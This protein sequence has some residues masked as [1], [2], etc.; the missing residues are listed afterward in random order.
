MAVELIGSIAGAGS[1]VLDVVKCLAA[2]IGRP[3]KY[4]YNYK[5]NIDNLQDGVKNLKNTSEEVQVNVVAAERN[6]EEIKQSVKDWQSKA[7]N[8]ITE[9][10]KLIEEKENNPRCFK[11]L[12]PNWII[13]YKR[14]KKA[15]KLKQDDISQLL[16]KNIHRFLPQEDKVSYP[17][18]HKEIWLRS[19]ED[20]LAFESR[21]STVKDVWGALNDENIYMMGV[22]GMGGLGKTTLVQE[23]GRQAEKDKL[24]EEIVFVEV[25][26]TLDVKKVQTEI[27]DKLGLKFNNESERASKLYERLK[28]GKKILLILDNVWEDLDLKTMGIPSK[29]DHGGCKLLLTTRN[30]DVLQKMDSQKNFG[31]SILQ[32]EE[33]WNL[34]MKMAG[35]VIQTR[36]LNSLP[37]DVCKECGGLPIVICTIAKALK[38]KSSP[39]D[40]KVALRELKAPS[41][42]K[43]IGLLEKE[44][45]KIALS[46]TYLRDDEL[47]KTFLISSLMKNNTSISDLFRHVVGLDILEGANLTMEDARDRLDKLVRELKDSCLLLD[48]FESGQFAMHDAIRA[49]AVT[50]AYTDHHVF[51]RRN[52]IEREWK[53]KDK[54][55]KCTKI[56]LPGNSTI[57]SQLWPKDLDCPNLEYFYMTNT[58]ASSY[59]IPEDFFTV[60]P[61]LK[62]LNLFGMQQSS[63]PSSLDLLTNLQ[64]LC[65]DHSKIEDVAIIRNLKQLK[66]LSLQYSNIKELPSEFGQLTQI[67]LLDLSDCRQ[68]KVI[69]PNLIPKLSQLEEL[70]IKGCC[71]QWKVEVLKELKHLTQLTTLT[72]DVTNDIV[73]P[74]GFFYRELKRYNISIRNERWNFYDWPNYEFSRILEFNYDSTI[75]LEELRILKNVELLRLVEFSDDDNNLKPIFNEKVIFS[76]LMALELKVTSSRKIWD[77]QPPTFMSSLTHLNLKRCRKIKYVFSFSIAKSL[78]TLQHLEIR[79]CEV[80]E[81]I[82]A[83]AEGANNFAFPQVTFLTLENLPKLTTFYHGIDTW[84]LPM[85][86]RL[87]VEECE[88]F[89]SKYLGFHENSLHNSEPK[90]IWLDNKINSDL[91]K[92]ELNNKLRWISW[93]SKSKTLE[94][95]CDKSTNIPL[96]LLQIF[97]NLKELQLESCGYKE[98][99]S[100]GKDEKQMQITLGPS[101]TSFQNL[102]VLKVS[103]CRELMKLITP[104]TA[105]NLVQ[106]REMSIE[107]CGMLIEI[108]ENEGERDATTSIRIVFD[109]LKKLSLRSLESLTCFC[110]GNYSFN[111]PSLEEIIIRECPNMKTFSQGILSTPKLHKINYESLAKDSWTWEKME[112]KNEGN[113]LNK[114]IQGACRKQDISVD[115]KYKAFQDI[116][117]T[118]ICYN[119]HP[120]SFYQN[121][122]HLILSSCGNINYAFPSSI[123]RSLHQLQHLKIHNCKVLEEIVAKEEGANKDDNFVFP[124]VTSLVLENLPEF[125]AFY[126]TFEWPMLQELVLKDCAKFMTS[127]YLSFQE[128][129]EEC[130]PHFSEPKSLFLNDKINSNLEK[131]ELKNTNREIKWQSQ[132][133]ALKIS[134]DKSANF[135][136]GLLQRFENTK[137]LRLDICDEYK[138]IKC[139]SDLPNL[140]VLHV[141]WCNRLT[142]LMPS[143]ASFQNLKVLNVSCC[144]W[145]MKLI[146]PSTTRSLVQLRELS[147]GYCG[148]MI[149][150]V[151]NE[152]DETTTEIVFENLKKLSLIRL[153]SLTCFCSGNYSF[154]FPSFEELIIEECPNMKTFSQ[155]ISSTPKLSKIT[156]EWEEKDLEN[157]GIELNTTI[158]QEHK[159]KMK[160]FFGGGLSMPKLQE[161]NERDCS[162]SDINM[163]IQ[164]LQ[165]D[166]SKIYERF[167][168]EEDSEF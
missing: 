123:A 108:I 129:N 40:W 60:M 143:S 90:F 55:K 47:K 82:V 64:T 132:S 96:G 156:Y 86:K 98:I 118:E 76:N 28:S 44:Y 161:L 75:S 147:I 145:L 19:N 151:E 168:E 57:I 43:F 154:N 103:W 21:N 131:M 56:S 78:Q 15:F 167:P 51:T 165:N 130:E 74:Q 49:V 148:M 119:Q 29:M 109:N 106:L 149:E 65:L 146:I 107:S 95:K 52:D 115:L 155:G 46:Y 37:Q 8:T 136:L 53:N 139:L 100:C 83:E 36:G 84:E 22:Y 50:I 140:E 48:S 54:L 150:I 2:P 58:W 6:V 24:F 160:T 69:A 23:V 33:A 104:S 94:I 14:S 138:E 127:K 62:V 13:R 116:N 39:S 85:L 41:P 133:K 73:L 17:T 71:I 63:L 157:G 117:S 26:E 16:D 152:G 112:V 164:Q 105:R 61:K 35:G 66:V 166:C 162:E 97:E 77:S 89:T 18:I 121:L 111:F 67:R 3:F 59:E 72:L 91:E 158:Q 153:E 159:K 144:E 120:N 81:E 79:D 137:E 25:T 126:H 20:Y 38:N 42:T 45:V 141:I 128:N 88:K 134:N 142:S 101:S 80:L 10:E 9:A 34:F 113:D 1:F 27:A 102:K 125:K 110:S 122:T 4:L 93:Q 31:M 11:G 92:L 68:L 124:H 7:N 32:E 114:T 70:Y 87:V 5:K 163:I 135:P 99:F 12:C 30:L